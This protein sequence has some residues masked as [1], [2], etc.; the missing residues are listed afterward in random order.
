MNT[1]KKEHI[2]SIIMA[3]VCVVFGLLFCI[4]PI[5]M[6]AFLETASFI[7]LF[8][9]GV[10]MIL[11]YCVVNT[12]VR[13]PIKLLKASIA[14]G[15]GILLICINSVLVICLGLIIVISG[16]L[17]IR[18]AVIDKKNNDK[19]WWTSLVIGIVLVLLGV[20]VAIL[21]N[22][23]VAENIVMIFYGIIIIIDGILRLVYTFILHREVKILLSKD[24]EEQTAEEI[25]NA[26]ARKE[27]NK[28]DK[29]DLGD[30]EEGFVSESE[31][32]ESK[33]KDNSNQ[34]E[35]GFV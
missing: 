26:K 29:E 22:T 23:A 12:E 16:A 33:D 21:Y 14:L 28:T 1:L 8:G 27:V 15:L 10:L 2:K 31:E 25:E 17:Y 30:N 13:E 34:D 35:E 4:I 24:N 7:I 11:S 20:T 3:S 6:L 5:K 19:N 18:A 32:P 9:Y